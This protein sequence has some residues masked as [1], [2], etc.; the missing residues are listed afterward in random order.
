MLLRLLPPLRWA[1]EWARARGLGGCTELTLL[2]RRVSGSFSGYQLTA[3]KSVP[4]QEGHS[5]FIPCRVY[6]PW[7]FWSNFP[8]AWGSWFKKEARYDRDPPGATNHPSREALKETEGRFHLLGDPRSYNCSLRIKD[9]RKTDTG[10][11]FFRVERGDDVKYNYRWDH[12]C[13]FVTETP[14][15]HIAG[16]LES[17]LPGNITCAVPWP[18]EQGTPP[19]F[20]W[21][22]ANLTSTLGPETPRSSVLTITPEPRHH[23]SNLTCRVTFPGVSVAVE[24]TVQ[25]SVA[26]E[27][28]PGLEVR[29]GQMRHIGLQAACGHHPWISDFLFPMPRRTCPSTSSGPTAQVGGASPTGA[30][31]GTVSLIKKPQRISSHNGPFPSLGALPSP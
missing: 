10:V 26:C 4:V 8:P 6:C 18:C 9:A 20:S 2:S 11:Y 25:L 30:V 13:V 12:L 29:R 22:G 17:G 27:C 3:P 15:V 1:G 21:T 23:G 14:D 31:E 5:V 19:A 16:T 28:R 7:R 24:R